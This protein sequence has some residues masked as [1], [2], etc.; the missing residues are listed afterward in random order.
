VSEAVLPCGT[1]T[2]V[3]VVFCVVWVVPDVST[4]VAGVFVLVLVLVFVFEEV[5]VLV[6][7]PVFRPPVRRE[8]M[9]SPAAELEVP[10]S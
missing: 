6:V 5:L 3:A 9:R 2:G 10:V 1:E 7:A 8:L 4:L